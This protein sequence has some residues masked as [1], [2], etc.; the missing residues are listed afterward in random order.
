M[1]ISYPQ[2]MPAFFCPACKLYHEFSTTPNE[3]KGV[4]TWNYDHDK[5]T[6]DQTVITNLGD[7]WICVAWVHD[8]LATFVS[9]TTHSYLDQTFKIQPG[10]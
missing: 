3:H 10:P 1:I 8:G 7:G 5:P 2:G 9:G 4:W 6:L